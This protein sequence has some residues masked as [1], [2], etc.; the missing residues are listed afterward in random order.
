M[1]AIHTLRKVALHIATA[2]TQNIF[3]SLNLHL[4]E[5]LLG[6]IMVW[7]EWSNTKLRVK[8]CTI[9]LQSYEQLCL[10]LSFPTCSL[11]IMASASLFWQDRLWCK[12]ETLVEYDLLCWFLVVFQVLYV[13]LPDGCPDLEWFRVTN[14]AWEPFDPIVQLT[15]AI[16]SANRPTILADAELAWP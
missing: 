9:I 15:S 16:A 5:A 3:T 8:Q 4:D 11:M 12:P 14:A 1:M 2:F 7:K 6:S 10:L 13:L